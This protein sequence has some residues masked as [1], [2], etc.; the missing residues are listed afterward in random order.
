MRMSARKISEGSSRNVARTT[1]VTLTAALVEEAKKL[2]VNI[3]LA[4]TWGLEQAV[5]KARTERWPGE[6]SDALNSYNEYIEKN[7]LPLEKWRLF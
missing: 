2:G 7:G 5:A 3:S 4:V 1:N 6:N